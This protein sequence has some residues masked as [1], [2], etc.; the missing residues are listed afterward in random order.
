MHQET[1]CPNALAGASE[2]SSVL[3]VCIVTPDLL[4]PVRNGGIG[5]SC[6]FLARE[7]ALAGHDVSILF[8]QYP[9]PDTKQDWIE[10]YSQRGIQVTALA[11]WLQRKGQGKHFPDHP[12]LFVAHAVHDWLVTEERSRPFDVVLFMEWQGHGFYSLHSKKNGFHFQNTALLVHIHSPSLWHSI[13]NAELPSHP[14]QALTW[15]MER[16]SVALADAVIT[17]SAHMLEWVQ[18]HGYT[19]PKLA[20]V[21]P[22]LLEV[23]TVARERQPGQTPIREFVFFGR[24][25]Y[26]K[27]LVQFCDAL[28][29]LAKEK[30]LPV[31]VT[32]M[33]K[34]A[35]V[36]SEHAALYIAGRSRRWPMS[37]RI[38][39]TYDHQQAL[40]Y[41]SEPGRLAVMPSV[42]DNS[43][44]TVY[45]CLAAQ[46][47]FVARNVGGVAELI[48]PKDQ[49]F[50]LCDDNPRSLAARLKHALKNGIDRPALAFELSENRQ[51]W[52]QRLFELVQT[53]RKQTSSFSKAIPPKA[54]PLV[55]VCLTHYNRPHF[56]RQ[57][58]DSLFKQDYPHFEVIL[59]D[60]GSPSKEARRTLQQLRP[61]FKKRGW[62]ILLLSNGYPGKARNAAVRQS[63]GEW[64][65][66]MDDDNVAKPRM[67]RRFVEAA[68]HSEAEL[69]TSVFDVFTGTAKPT[70]TTPIQERFLPVGGI[71]SYSVITNVIGDTNALIKRSLFERLG[72]FTEDYGLGHEDFELYA[73]AVLAKAAIGVIPEPLFWYRRHPTS[74]QTATNAAANRMRSL[75]PFLTALPADLGELAVLTHALALKDTTLE[76]RCR[77]APKALSSEEKR[78]FA[79]RDPNAA[80][81]LLLAADELL[82][83]GRTELARQLLQQLE[84]TDR[85]SASR[86]EIA[87]LQAQACEAVITGDFARVSACATQVDVFACEDNPRA[88]FYITLLE[89]LSHVPH[90]GN[91]VASLQKECCRRLLQL[92]SLPLQGYLTAARYLFRTHHPEQALAVLERFL[93]WSETRYLSLRPDVAQA[94]SQGQFTCGLHHYALHGNADGTPWPGEEEII[95]L[96]RQYKNLWEKQPLSFKA[97]F[98]PYV[99]KAFF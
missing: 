14:M 62:K 36:G 49:K 87:I 68:L 35:W 57:A 98:M 54:L 59:A 40:A 13:N 45:E 91:A 60:D 99:E 3:R 69:L 16:Q 81:S 65:L 63:R 4:G 48:A 82:R 72:G 75:R 2:E 78:S 80:D 29:L 10:E 7:L 6:T 76:E 67:I 51:A 8:T 55:S 86:R 61:E 50:C 37:V 22:N 85:L 88:C 1:R 95:P 23:E 79:T 71:L 21:Q 17:P 33:G 34:C 9:L 20:L 39:S 28:D 94:V 90:Q 18:Q 77:T 96:L 70:P 41:L 64:V 24:L 83:R 42:A 56:L 89:A 31:A 25:E 11:S 53:I 30:Q 92:P 73:R 19:L 97:R 12:P 84:D 58:V 46:I 43:P 47:P 52:Q 38:L 93:S 74:V 26:R 27:G 15:F 66:F 32:F 44:Y 5:T